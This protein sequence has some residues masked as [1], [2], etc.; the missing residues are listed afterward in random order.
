MS[1]AIW[2]ILRPA[3]LSRSANDRK[4]VPVIGKLCPAATWALP[5]AWA[6]PHPDALYVSETKT[7]LSSL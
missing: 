2:A 1:W 7:V 6:P 5:Y 3:A 4:I